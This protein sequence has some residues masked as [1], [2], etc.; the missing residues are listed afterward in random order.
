MKQSPE[1]NGYVRQIWKLIEEEVLASMGMQSGSALQ[2]FPM[3]A[4]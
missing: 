3:V 1:F 4:D 2:N